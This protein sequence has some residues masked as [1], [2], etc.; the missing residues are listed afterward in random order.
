MAWG[1]L[2]LVA[3]PNGAGKTTLVRSLKDSGGLAGH[4]I[5][6]ADD[7]T[8]VKIREAGYAGFADAPFELLKECFIHSA[9]EV[10]REATKRLQ[11]GEMVCLETV[12]STGKYRSLVNSLQA[13]GGSLEL[14]YVALQSHLISRERISFRVLKGGH[15]V[16]ES[17]LAER[18]RRSLEELKWF[19][20]RADRFSIYDNTRKPPEQLAEG[21]R[22]R[23]AWLV[24]PDTVFS[25]LRGI[26]EE[27]FKDSP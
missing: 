8:L 22:G 24:Q 9:E 1:T 4:V 19:V 16:P 12:L 5:L 20:S 7:S 14:V 13:N 6:N 18:W 10:Y 23:I 2:T 3:G 26:L 11:S 17:K 21:E 15:D 27:A 25:E